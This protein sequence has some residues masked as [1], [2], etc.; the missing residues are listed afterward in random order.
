MYA[1][2]SNDD[3]INAI[4]I[5]SIDKYCSGDME[6]TNLNA[7]AD[8]GL[9]DAVTGGCFHTHANGVWFSFIPA[10]PAINVQ[11][12]SGIPSGTI[13][14]I[15]MSLYTGTCSD[16]T[17]VNCSIG[18]NEDVEWTS[19]GLTLGQR[20]YLLVESNE[21]RG[22]EGTF[23]LCI[24]DFFAPPTPE[25]D[26]ANA[27]VLCDKSTFTVENL[28]SGGE[29]ND[30]MIGSCVGVGQSQ[31][32]ASAWYVW[33]ADEPGTLTFTLTPTNPNAS[34]EDLDFVVYEFPDGLDQCDSRFSVRCM[35][36]GESAGFGIDSSPCWGPTGL[37]LESSDTEE[38]AGCQTGDDNFVAALD[39]VSGVSYG[40]IVNNFSQSGFGFDIDFGG[41]GT[42]L[43]P[44][45]DLEL[46]PEFGSL[47]ECDRNVNAINRSESEAD[48]IVNL[49]WNF[50]AGAEPQTAGGEGPHE[51]TYTSFG[52][53]S[54]LLSV[55]SERGC[56]VSVV[57]QVFIERCCDEFSDLDLDAEA[58]DLLCNNIPT[59]T[60]SSM[61]FGGN[62]EYLFSVNGDDF[63]P[64]A[65][66]TDL[67]IGDYELIVQDI[68]GCE[69]TIVVF[70]SEPPA[71]GVDA[72]PDIEIDLGF[73]DTLMATFT[74]SDAEI[75][76]EWT[77]PEGLSCTDCPDPIVLAPGTQTYTVSIIDSVGC[78]ISDQVTVT[79][80]IIRPI[81]EPNII[82]PNDPTRDNTFTLGFGPQA[83]LVK[84]FFIYDRWGSLIF[85][86][87]DIELDSRNEMVA[88]WD[89][90]FGSGLGA[91]GSNTF[92]VDPGVFVWYVNVLFIDNVEQAF[93]GDVTVV[94]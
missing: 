17:Y 44:N 23:K 34:Q 89:G 55:E 51:I 47:L 2:P 82:A 73:T 35:L 10:E 52:E 67:D 16:L 27:V 74:P 49:A 33:T 88:G 68:K 79:T 48:S 19:T 45:P 56:I 4:N 41:T 83:A 15:Q 6:F 58:T 24:N 26:C 37:S 36:S 59:G 14:D 62:P 86:G 72:G 77:P 5:G 53:K 60:I 9:P 54:V 50:G 84:E 31:E 43:G 57:K 78:R 25:A 65:N 94:K 11:V 80:N 32:L 81:Y 46:V 40:F 64:S 75:R 61:A 3:C 70:I 42:F 90:R 7:E 8:L 29:I 87:T 71:L 1:Q 69:D 92:F 12:F 39:M 66:Y 28:S 38:F 85:K 76:W 30:E 93:A 91:T 22:F 21:D 63:V 20:Y 13:F 18:A